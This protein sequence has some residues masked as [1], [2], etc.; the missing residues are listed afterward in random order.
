MLSVLA[1]SF[2]QL[3]DNEWSFHAFPVHLILVLWRYV[4]KADPGATLIPSP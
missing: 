3:L 2:N 4:V 1:K